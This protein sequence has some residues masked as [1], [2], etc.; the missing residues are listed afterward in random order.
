MSL[1]IGLMSGTS[2]DGVD[3]CLVEIKQAEHPKLLA[4]TYLAFPT[5]LQNHIISLY[6]ASINDLENAAK[7][8]LTLSQYYAEAVAQLLLLSGHSATQISAI[9]CHGQTLRHR[10][11]NGFSIQQMDGARLAYLTG[12]DVICDFRS[13]DMA[14]GGQGAPLVPA[15][16]QAI[17]TAREQPQVFLNLGGIANISCFS[18]DGQLLCGFD[19]GPANALMDDWCQF[20]LGISYDKNGDWAAQGQAN[21]QLLKIWLDDPYF[22]R[23]PPKSTGR[24]YFN[25]QWLLNT[26]TLTDYAPVDVQASLL[27]LTAISCATSITQ[28]LPSAEVWLAGGGANNAFLHQRLAAHLGSQYKLENSSKIGLS[29]DGLEAT[30]FAWLAYC[31]EHRRPLKLNQ[32]TGAQ[33]NR[34][35][36]CLYPA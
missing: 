22:K 29:A 24:E 1:Y 31:F 20:Q 33:D 12:I 11:E 4:Q 16:Q 9:G 30:C 25:L 8:A 13:A 26:A 19:T 35:A 3:A 34:V 21:Q 5:S 36:G 17:L 32:V 6:Q 18:A 15:F 27:E 10:P 14:A 2:A 23:L 28:T 7:L